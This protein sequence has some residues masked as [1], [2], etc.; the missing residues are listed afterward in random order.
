VTPAF[1]EMK[2]LRSRE[3]VRSQNLPETLDFRGRLV[4]VRPP[5]MDFFAS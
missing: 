1:I 5:D 4:E 2:S 3:L